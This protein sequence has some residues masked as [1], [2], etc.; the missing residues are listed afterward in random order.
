MVLKL[1]GTT[2]QDVMD[3]LSA[4]PET[5]PV[6]LPDTSDMG[7]IA[8]PEPGETIQWEKDLAPGEYVLICATTRPPGAWFGSGL[9][10]IE[11]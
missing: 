9:T 2:A 7:G 4:E 8:P 10:V 5:I 11:G 6:Y 1:E 3:L